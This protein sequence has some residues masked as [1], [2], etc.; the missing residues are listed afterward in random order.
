MPRGYPIKK[1]PEVNGKAPKNPPA[2]D[3]APK[4]HTEIF[5]SPSD[6]G[7]PPVGK[8]PDLEKAQEVINT[9]QEKKVKQKKTPKADLQAQAEAKEKATKFAEGFTEFIIGGTEMLI[10]RMP[11]PTPL[12]PFEKEQWGKQCENMIVK[13][14]DYLGVWSTEIAF[15]TI[16]AMIFLPRMKK[17]EPAKS[18][19][20]LRIVSKE[21]LSEKLKEQAPPVAP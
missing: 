19:E 20:P 7:T 2:S 13:Y 9:H 11:T 12:K 6:S 10:E 14:F 15:L 8:S 17:P 1:N 5:P 4:V 21:E 3:P 16:G 18:P